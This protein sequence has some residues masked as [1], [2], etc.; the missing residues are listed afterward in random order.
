[1]ATHILVVDDEPLICQLL[2]YQLSGAGYQVSSYQNGAQAL[3]RFAQEQPDLVLLD[4]MMPGT[5]G[6]DICRQIRAT[7]NVPVIMLTAKQAD[8]D[9]VTG[10]NCGADDYVGKP[11]SEQQL[12]ARIATVLRRAAPRHPYGR[13]LWSPALAPPSPAPAPPP[14]R[15]PANVGADLRVR[16]ASMSAAV[17]LPQA[18]A[19]E[20]IRL[21]PRLAEARQQRNLSLHDAERICNV[22]WDFLQ[23][24][25][26]EQ[27]RYLPR[28]EMRSAL[29]AYSTMLDIDLKPYLQ[30]RPPPR[31]R[32]QNFPTAHFA[33]SAILVLMIM[34]GVAAL[35]F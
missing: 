12:L 1:M 33:L 16:P 14:P 19:T 24:I 27:F 8:D 18:P 28:D 10:L 23:A 13:S 20:P 7:S 17:A 29:H 30:R 35:L 21:G 34:L 6:W 25:E 22:R 4:V 3:L 32:R 31:R 15:R 2:E 9:V 26:Q 5:S 11:F